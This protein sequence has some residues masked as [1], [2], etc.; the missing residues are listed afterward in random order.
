MP[1]TAATKAAA[2]RRRPPP[3]EGGHVAAY[4]MRSLEIPFP[5]ALLAEVERDGVHV[6]GTRRGGFAPLGRRSVAHV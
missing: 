6:V 1:E 4:R 3:R 5:Q 2:A